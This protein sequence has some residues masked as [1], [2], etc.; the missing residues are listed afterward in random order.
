M[1]MPSTFS[2]RAISGLMFEEMGSVNGGIKIRVG[3][4]AV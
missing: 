1:L 3:K 2:Q 4:G